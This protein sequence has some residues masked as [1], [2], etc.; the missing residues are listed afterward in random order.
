VARAP[1]NLGENHQVSALL[2]QILGQ[3]AWVVY[4]VVGLVVFLEDAVFVGFVVPGETAAILGGVTAAIGHTSVVWM[5]VLV[6]TA[7]IV[8]DSV[9]YE[10]GRL[11]GPRLTEARWLQRFRPR[12]ERAQDFLRERGAVA[13]FLAR[14]TAFFRA[15]MPALAGSSRM[16][17]RVFLPWN[18]LGGLAW[19]LAVVIGGYLAGHSYRRLEQWLGTGSAVLIVVLLLGGFLLYR[20]HQKR[21]DA[22]TG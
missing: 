1:R 8:G 16:P 9:G 7:A 2:E 21:A 22:T 17:Y 6:V 3:P 20:R 13:V 14:W 12:I 11:M 10:L 18:A 5:A 15:V 19:G 4:L